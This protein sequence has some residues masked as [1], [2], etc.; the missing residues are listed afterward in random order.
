MKGLDEYFKT[1]W[2]K[3]HS[4]VTEGQG[5]GHKMFV[6]KPY[7]VKVM[8]SIFEWCIVE[9]IQRSS[10]VKVKV[11]AYLEVNQKTLHFIGKCLQTVWKIFSI[12]YKEVI[13]G[14]GQ[15]HKPVFADFILPI[16]SLLL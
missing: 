4:E 10:E 11:I 1:V 9:V 7:R 8:E 2:H 14:Q 13:W 15:G 3:G 6:R 12:A 16:G 5:Q